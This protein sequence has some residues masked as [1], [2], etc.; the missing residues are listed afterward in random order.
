MN[1][2]YIIRYD[3][4]GL[5][6]QNRSMFE[7][8]LCKNIKGQAPKEAS[9]NIIRIQGRVLVEVDS[10]FE[11]EIEDA[12]RRTPGIHSF[13]KATTVGK[14]IE[15]LKEAGLKELQKNWD[16][17]SPIEFRVS[18]KRS[19][20]EYPIKSSEIN[21]A[22][23]DHIFQH[24]GNEFLKVNLKKPQLEI[25][26]EIHYQRAMVHSK[27]E[28]SLGGLPVG[29]AGDVLCLL[30][31]GI[32]SPVAAFQMLRRGCRVHFIFFENRVFLGRAAYEKVLRLAKTLSKF[33]GFCILNVVPFTDIQVAIRD[34]CRERNRVIL[35]RRYMYRIA[36]RLLNEKGYHG[37]INGEC[38]GQV[39]SQTLE[40]M[41]VVNDVV[42]CPVYRPLI[43]MDKNDIV[44]IAKKIDTFDISSEDA[45]DCCSVFMPSRPAT[46]AK[47]EFL[48]DDETRLDSEAL[49]EK[50]ISEMEVI[51]I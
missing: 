18:A 30:S 5:K 44:N 11:E 49:I 38:L 25:G 6:G 46:K 29:T 42:E 1:S 47:T 33:Q 7:R 45:P 40:N 4:I 24:Y 48:L 28:R 50:A 14:D 19:D 12:L 51:K 15:A 36:E 27:I 35:Y 21:Q 16:G 31:G 34:E 13:S 37:L 3:E 26:L 39:A 22:V 17:K 20:K 41:K 23:G 2:L 32:D 10:E 43:S 9:C 8:R